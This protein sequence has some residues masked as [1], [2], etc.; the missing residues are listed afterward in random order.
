MAQ[1]LDYMG[2]G[3]NPQLAA[4]Y[5][6]TPVLATAYGTSS[7]SAHQIVG[8]QYFTIANS[9]TSSFKLPLVNSDTGALLGDRYIVGN[10]T[11]ASV[12]VYAANNANGSVVTLYTTGASTA[13]TTGVSVGVGSLVEFIPVTV[14]TW[15][16]AYGSA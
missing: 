15:V 12:A 4:R 1:P 9:G 7:G 16:V 11:S 14:S 8:S 3:E 10:L 13:G 2:L 5:A 6:F